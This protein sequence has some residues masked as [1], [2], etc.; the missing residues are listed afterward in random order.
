V[1]PAPGAEPAI[2]EEEMNVIDEE[3]STGL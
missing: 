1:Q 3:L 2:S